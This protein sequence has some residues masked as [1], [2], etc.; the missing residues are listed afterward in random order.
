VPVLLAHARE[1][2]TI[3]AGQSEELESVLKRAGA[4]VQAL[5]FEDDDQSLH[6]E[7]DRVAFLRALATFLGTHLS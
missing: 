6:N 7:A 5:Y 4:P 2:F 1:D 3:P